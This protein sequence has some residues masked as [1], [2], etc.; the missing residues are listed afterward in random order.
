M[1]NLGQQKNIIQSDFGVESL[2]FSFDVKLNNSNVAQQIR[3]YLSGNRQ[4]F[5]VKLNLKGTSFQL[6][7]W[8]ALQTIPYGQTATYQDIANKI[9]QPNAVRAVANAVGANPIAILIPCHRVIRSDGSLGGYKWGVENKKY[10]IELES[11]PG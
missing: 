5:D 11:L 6:T 1:A 4:D 7:V 2:I 8:Q 3:E 10:L 9:G